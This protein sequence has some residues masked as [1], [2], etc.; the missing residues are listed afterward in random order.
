MDVVLLLVWLTLFLTMVGGYKLTAWLY[1]DDPLFGLLFGTVLALAVLLGFRALVLVLGVLVV[2]FPIAYALSIVR[3]RHDDR[4][5]LNRRT[6][7]QET[8]A[9]LGRRSTA[10]LSTGRAA[11]ARAGNRCATIARR[12]IDRVRGVIIDLRADDE[13]TSRRLET[14]RERREHLASCV[15]CGT[16]APVDRTTG[17]CTECG[18]RRI[19]I[20]V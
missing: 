20:D 9:T 8:G 15:H 1:R 6:P 19:R 14:T 5:P 17:R 11:V 16:A 3:A 2:T 4:H 12:G 7:V 18:R 10:A 13:A